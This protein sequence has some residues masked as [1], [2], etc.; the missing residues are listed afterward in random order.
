MRKM[1]DNLFTNFEFFIPTRLYCGL[2][3]LNQLTEICQELGSRFLLVT[4]RDLPEAKNRILDVLDRSHF[5]ITTFYLESP[6]PTC[7]FIDASREA[8]KS[9][10]F[11]GIIALGG[12]S[13]ID[14]VKALSIG[15]THNQPIWMY[16]NLSNRPPVPLE[17]SLL[18]VVAIPTTAGTGSE[19]TPYA[20]LTNSDTKQKGTIQEATIFPRTAILDPSL[21]QTMPLQLTA[22]T[23]LDAFA[24]ALESYINISRFSL[25]SEWAS[26]EAIR[27]IFE[28]LPKVYASPDDLELRSKMAWASALAGMA[29]AHRGTTAAHAIAEPL[30]ALTHVPHAQSV[31][32]CTLPVLKHTCPAIS[33]K[34]R[35]LFEATFPNNQVKSASKAEAFVHRTEELFSTVAMNHTLKDSISLKD[36]DKFAESLLDHVLTYKFRPLKQHPMEFDKSELLTIIHEI[37]Q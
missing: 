26:K 14:M 22:A 19:V 35:E 1:K 16:A 17:H 21:T 29:I 7:Q 6:E 25:V 18:P 12:G 8:L 23:G 20:V 15:L 36:H 32:M 34:L 27:L 30:G 31:A 11:D 4:C 28:N 37:I 3:A 24:H 9:K 2:D 10:Q 13:A 33:T 5:S